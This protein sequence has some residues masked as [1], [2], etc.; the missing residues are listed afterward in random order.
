MNTALLRRI[1]KNAGVKKKAL[2]WTKR[3]SANT[4]KKFGKLKE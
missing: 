1:Y 3:P 2:K 4:L